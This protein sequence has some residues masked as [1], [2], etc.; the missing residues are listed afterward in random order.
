MMN[1][2]NLNMIGTAGLTACIA[3]VM[4]LTITGTC[5]S[6]VTSPHSTLNRRGITILVSVPLIPALFAFLATI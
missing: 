5:A 4:A 6:A 1:S 3:Y 2:M